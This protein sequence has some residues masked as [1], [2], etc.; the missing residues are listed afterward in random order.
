[1]KLLHP[2]RVLAFLAAVSLI[3]VGFASFRASAKPRKWTPPAAAP[4]ATR[5][6][7]YSLAASGSVSATGMIR[8][9]T[10][11]SPGAELAVTAGGSGRSR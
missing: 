9:A 7:R 1:M 3:G 4:A 6:P 5:R 11:G 8:S 2:L 10:F